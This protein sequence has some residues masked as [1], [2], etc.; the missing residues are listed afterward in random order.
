MPT[1]KCLVI[2]AS[3]LCASGPVSLPTAGDLTPLLCQNVLHAVREIGYRVVVTPHILAEWQGCLPV[4][5]QIQQSK[6]AP[7]WLT[8][9]TT[10]Q[11]FH[12]P[13]I[14]PNM[15][16]RDK[17]EHLVAVEHFLVDEGIRQILRDD[18]HLIE[19]ALAT[20]RIVLSRDVQ[21]RQHFHAAAYHIKELRAV[22]WVDPCNDADDCVSWLKAGA[23]LEKKRRLGFGTY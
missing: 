6:Y 17:L 15:Q 13:E 5:R 10:R 21:A 18:V 8:Y 1:S 23:K 12:R 3:V 2:D 16:L 7:A 4:R 9:M 19:A 14:P 11:R 20:D 22:V